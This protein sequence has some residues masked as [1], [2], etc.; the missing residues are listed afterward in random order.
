[1]EIVPETGFDATDRAIVE[2]LQADG[3]MANVDLA[4]AVSLS[5]SACLRRT[6]A[7]EAA[8]VI[9]GYRADVDRT[10]VGQGLTVF[11]GLRVDQHSRETSRAIEDALMAVPNVVACHVVTGESDF[12]VEAVVPDI[13]AYERLLLDQIIAIPAVKDARSTFAI[14]TVS[15]RG[16]IPVDQL[17]H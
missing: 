6:K 7:L 3:R 1:V 4:D 9:A 10:R 17:T 14:R 8:G 16:P 2:H 11:I 5:P 12:L 13:L 15:S